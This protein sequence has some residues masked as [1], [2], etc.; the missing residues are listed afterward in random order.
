M[1]NQ[2][3]ELAKTHN[4]QVVEQLIEERVSRARSEE[5]IGIYEDLLQTIW[6]RILPTLGRV[7]LTAII[8][9]SLVI[10]KESHA[11]IGHIHVTIEGISFDVL[12]E[13]MDDKERD[14]LRDALKELVANLFDILAMLTGDILVRQLIKEIDGRAE[15]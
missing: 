11:L 12:R 8:E 9:R 14:F 4:Q 10:T 5:V 7:T 3:S 15:A 13:Q 1:I 6:S 2:E